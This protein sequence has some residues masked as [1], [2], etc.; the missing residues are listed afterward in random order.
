MLLEATR[1][2]LHARDIELHIVGDGAMRAKL[3]ALAETLEL[4]EH[5]IF[6]GFVSQEECARFL[7]DC[8]VLVLPS[9]Y[10]CGGAVVLEAMAMGL[11]VIATKWGGPADYLDETSGIL[12]EPISRERFILILTGAMVRLA[13]SRKFAFQLGKPDER[14][15]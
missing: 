4:K 8:D 9:L 10:E 15:L 14:G 3:E 7:M 5:V 12:V 13:Q 6:H 1:K 11:P 2:V